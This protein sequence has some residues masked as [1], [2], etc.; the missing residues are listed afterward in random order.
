MPALLEAGA[1]LFA[2]HGYSGT[3]TQAV[4]HEAGVNKAMISYHFGG[5][6]GLY[7][8]VIVHL[9]DE[10]RPALSGLREDRDRP[11][12]ER[13]RRFIE[14]LGESFLRRPELGA[15]VLREHLSGGERLSA[16]V[17]SRH[18]GE[19]FATTRSIVE[20]GVER[21]ELRPVDPHA[22]HL[23]LIG[24]LVFF[25]ASEPYRRRAGDAGE[26]PAPAP[27]RGDYIDHLVR[28]LLDGLRAEAGPD[29]RRE[30]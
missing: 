13:L 24:S 8:A 12:P 19:F 4:A 26:L 25:L 20:A 21:N 15:I 14:T 16:E 17:M 9:V 5:K 27:P 7:E 30:S 23:S 2:R 11:S 3:R 18:V 10:F 1:R 28:L 6:A 22:L 29:T